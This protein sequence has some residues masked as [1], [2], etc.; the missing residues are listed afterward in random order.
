MAP[1]VP[2]G[3]RGSRRVLVLTGDRVGPAMAGPAIRA[4]ELARVLA[5]DGHRVVV[6]TPWL[7]DTLPSGGEGITCVTG[8]GDS[9]RSLVAETDVVV[10]MTGVL[11]EHGWLADTKRRRANAADPLWVVADAYDPVLFEVLAGDGALGAAERSLRAQDASARMC[12]ALWWVDLVLCATENQRH[13]LLGVLAAWGRIG[14]VAWDDDARLR[15]AVAVVPFGLPA[16]PPSVAAGDPHPLS[17]PGGPFATGDR[18]LLWGGGLWDWLDPVTLVSAVA[19]CADPTVKVFFMAGAHP[20][21]SVP[22][23][24]MVAATRRAA[25]QQ[26]LD[27]HGTGQVRFADDWIGYGERAGYLTDA[28]IGVSLAPDHAESVFAYR[29]RVLDYLWASL[30]VLHSAPSGIHDDLAALIRAHDLGVVVVPGD[31]D[32]CVAAI[33]QLIRPDWY[34]DARSRIAEV[35]QTLTWPTVSR[36][37][38]DFCTEPRTLLSEPPSSRPRPGASHTKRSIA[39]RVWSSLRG[40]GA[41]P[42]VGDGVEVVG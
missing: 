7:D 14:P 15:S 35:A 3:G 4:W 8:W 37:L 12:D 2:I 36:P 9:L 41:A 13:L 21:P 28:T 18:I 10:G 32:G 23:M 39:R 25:A 11:H 29:T 16:E 20:T 22:E 27:E 19:R 5:G 17:G 38:R 40:S 6:A 26:G 24:D 1:T 42:A 33:G 31:V 34:A 30:P